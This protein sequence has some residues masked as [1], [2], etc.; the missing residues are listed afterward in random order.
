M[1]YLISL[2]FIISIMMNAEAKIVTKTVEYKL[3]DI[4]FEGFSAYDDSI[5]KKRPGILVVH[6][7]WGLNNYIKERSIALAKL[8]YIAFAPDIY[9]KGVH[10]ANMEEAGKTASIYKMDRVLMRARASAGLDQLKKLPFIDTGKLA[11]IGYCFGGTT[12]LELARSGAKI[13]ELFLSMADS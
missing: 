7:W 6:E 3:G 8:G 5:K 4:T 9:G 2:F 1:K 12:V 11:A 13:W 10:P